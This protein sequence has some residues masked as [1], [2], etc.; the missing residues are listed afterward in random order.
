MQDRFLRLQERQKNR[1]ENMD[2]SQFKPDTKRP[3]RIVIHGAEGVG[4]TTFAC[5]VPNP[6][7]MNLERGI[8]ER[9]IK[10]TKQFNPSS[11]AE[12]MD[13]IKTLYKSEHS[14]KT[15]IIDTL[16]ALDDMLTA[17]TRAVTGNN[18][19]SANYG[20]GYAERS[21]LWSDIISGLTA[22]NEKGMTILCLCHTATIEMKDPLLPVYDKQALKLYKTEMARFVDWS[23][24]TGYAI[25]KTYT[26]SSDGKRNLAKTA[27][28]HVI[29][30]HTNPA[31]I[32][33]NRYDMPPEIPMVWAEMEKYLP[34]LTDEN[35]EKME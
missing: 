11:Y 23:D 25:V 20:A 16:D 30:T 6:V 4:K 14:Y 27:G 3:P 24:V 34:V 35:T 17:H 18:N 9:Y 12:C 19:L 26:T 5:Q 15:L 22:L 33:K 29:L 32:A 7:M 8:P 10:T 28:E 13:M 2:I 31:Y 21:K 1:V